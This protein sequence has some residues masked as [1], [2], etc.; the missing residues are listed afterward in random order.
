MNGQRL[1][2]APDPRLVLAVAALMVA[3]GG[4]APPAARDTVTG[5][6]L[7]G[8]LGGDA[9]LEG[10]CAWLE[11]VVGG[12]A[13]QPDARRYQPVWPDGYK[14]VFEPLRVLSPAG[15]PLAEEGQVVRVS[16]RL[17]ADVVTACQTGPVFRVTRIVSVK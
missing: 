6:D 5:V 3:C 15:R 7:A 4:G 8:R 14:V 11:A 9:R 1:A 17:A 16:G 10:G 13:P 2:A 12:P